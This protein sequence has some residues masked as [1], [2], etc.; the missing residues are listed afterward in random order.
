M[1]MLRRY[2]LAI[3]QRLVH[4]AIAVSTAVF[5]RVTKTMSIALLLTKN[6]DRAGTVIYTA[7]R[8]RPVAGRQRPT[9]EK[10]WGNSGP[11]TR[12]S[13]HS[14]PATLIIMDIYMAHDPWQDL[15]HNAPYEKLQKNV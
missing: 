12:T 11:V 3:A 2:L 1:E 13:L 4:C 9:G 15:G 7:A 14:S 8:H 5:G 10:G 6:R